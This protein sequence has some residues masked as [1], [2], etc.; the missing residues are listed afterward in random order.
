MLEER[1]VER[2]GCGLE[3][4]GGDLQRS[5]RSPVGESEGVDLKAD[6]SW[7]GVRIDAVSER[8]FDEGRL[9]WW[10]WV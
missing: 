8:P 2:V 5:V 10:P 7:V 9:V 1:D 4:E 6:F 3:G